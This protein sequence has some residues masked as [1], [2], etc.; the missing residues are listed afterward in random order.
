MPEITP[1]A[2][3]FHGG[4]H[5]GTRGVNLE[6]ADPHL[7]SD[8][9]F[10]AL[11]DA[12]RRNGGSA[13][14]FSAPFLAD[15]PAPPFLLTS[16]FPR[17]GDVRF[18]PMPVDLSRLFQSET[19]RK[20]RKAIKGVRYLSEGLLRKAA[21]GEPLDDWLYPEDEGEEPTTGVALQGGALWLTLDEAERLPA[22]L[23]RKAGR[24]RALR[25]LSVWASESVPRVTVSRLNSA[26]NIFHSGRVSFAEGCG[27]W[28][29]VA[30]LRPE[31]PVGADQVPYSQAFQQ[32]LTTLREDG[33][34]GERSVGCGAFTF[35]EEK[36]ASWLEPAAGQPALLLSRYH[37]RPQ[38]LPDALSAPGAAYSL[39]SVAGWLRSPEGPAQRRKRL[40]MVAEGSLVS[41]PRFPAGDVADVRPTYRHPAG[42]LPH[43][44]YRYGLA[45][46]VGWSLAPPR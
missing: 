17:A 40:Y 29:G 45:L 43:P 35:R 11:V 7:P 9:L 20:R 27:L 46:A 31:A 37:P 38:E 18:Y 1:Y 36:P 8:T 44:V 13:E 12:W 19:L 2:L 22:S 28:F 14:G 10:A 32:A 4:F 30:W 5:V 24:R 41:P 34:G 39:L 42:D 21:S 16:G 15:P 6:E 25:Y 26:S 33:L 23:R 3:T